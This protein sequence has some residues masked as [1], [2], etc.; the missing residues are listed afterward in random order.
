MFDAVINFWFV[1]NGAQQWWRNDPEFD[2]QCRDRFAR[3]HAQAGVGELFAWRAQPEGRLAEI[4][5]LDQL[6][7]NMYRGEARAFAYDPVALILAQECVHCGVDLQL[8]V[9][10]RKFIYMPYMHSESV[11]VHH[12]AV[13]LFTALE[14]PKTLDFEFRHQEIIERFGRYPHRNTI[15]GRQ[16]SAAEESFLNEPGSSF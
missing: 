15:L 7:R 8:P 2:Q 5:L 10:Q 12:E 13:R 3:L 1:E 16:S 9:M 14:D 6:S 11:A 4:L